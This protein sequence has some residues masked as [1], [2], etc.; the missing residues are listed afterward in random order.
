MER[1]DTVA[2]AEDTVDGVWV[3]EIKP[4]WEITAFAEAE[5]LRRNGFE[6]F[7]D[8]GYLMTDSPTVARRAAFV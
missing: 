5:E 4:G 6:A 2:H 3:Y 7:V 8:E 1:T